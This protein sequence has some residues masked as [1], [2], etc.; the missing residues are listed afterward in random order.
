M[1]RVRVAPAAFGVGVV[2]HGHRDGN[3][4]G[5]RP[6]ISSECLARLRAAERAA[7]RH[8]ATDVLLCG[9]GVLGFAS[10]A[11]QMACAWR[12]P[13]VR[14]WLDQD[15]ADSAENARQALRWTRTTGVTRLVVVSSWWHVR[16]R[17]YYRPF[18]ALGVSVRHVGARRRDRVLRHL[19]HEL[20]YMPRA[21]MSRD[22]VVGEPV[23]DAP[24]LL[25]VRR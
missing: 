3:A 13:R 19:A 9:A 20:R 8:A 22:A 16:L 21:L 2:V 7:A 18:R 23:G 1:R 4:V 14:L 15:S 10:E 25:A 5:G 12:G 6:W 17:V 11:R 24:A